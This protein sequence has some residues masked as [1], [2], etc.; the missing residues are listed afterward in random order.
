MILYIKTMLSGFFILI[1]LVITFLNQLSM[2]AGDRYYNTALA[3][4]SDGLYEDAIESCELALEEGVVQT[5]LVDVYVIAGRCSAELDLND[6]AI[7]YYEKAIELDGDDAAKWTSLG[8]VYR[9]AGNYVKALEHYEKAL[10]F[11]PDYAEVHSS[12]GVL[13][14]L[15]GELE[16]SIA[17]FK[18]AVKLDPSVATA[19][20][21][22]AWALA[23]IGDF[24][25]AEKALR[26]SIMLGYDNAD[27]VREKIDELKANAEE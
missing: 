24:E 19:H 23:E 21:N 17:S 9:Q 7:G 3:E 10:E 6:S 20:G 14:M 22:L 26:Q 16:E 18:K 12:I 15:E 5:E 2:S 1:I 13:Q 8:V 27:I 4:Y 11:D 25:E